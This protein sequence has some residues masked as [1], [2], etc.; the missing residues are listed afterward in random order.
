VIRLWCEG[1][2]NPLK[3]KD[4]NLK[5]TKTQEVYEEKIAI[6]GR[7]F[8]AQYEQTC[9]IIG[10]RYI[11]CQVIIMIAFEW[12]WKVLKG[13]GLVAVTDDRELA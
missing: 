4:L 1:V 9:R 11:I 2:R 8:E 6:G 10:L 12:S 7:H 5:G 13:R 3:R